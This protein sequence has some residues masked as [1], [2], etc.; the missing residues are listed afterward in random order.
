MKKIGLV[1]FFQGNFGSILQCYATKCAIEKEGFE[2]EILFQTDNISIKNVS[3]I[4]PKLNNAIRLAKN[5]ISDPTYFHRWMR[6]RKNRGGLTDETHHL[7]DNFVENYIR[8]QGY[9]WDELCELAKS[10]EYV[11]FVVGSDQVWNFNN[12]TSKIYGLEF[13]PREKR[14]ALSVSLGVE[15]ANNRFLEL[16]KHNLSLFDRISVREETAMK[17][18][19]K[20]GDFEIYRLSDPT[21]LLEKKDWESIIGTEQN[22]ED[23]YLLVHFLNYPSDLAIRTINKQQKL[24]QARVLCIGYYYDIFDC[25]GWEYVDCNPFDYVRYINNAVS[26]YTDSFHTTLFSI[27]FNKSFAVFERMYTHGYPQTSRINNLL[28]IYDK[29]KCFIRSE[30][31]EIQDV[32]DN[33]E[34]LSFERAKIKKYLIESISRRGKSYEGKNL[35][36]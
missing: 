34:I 36:S 15:K 29:S 8:P 1:T 21:I 19:S 25:M 2:C 32:N 23:E 16:L 33:R 6:Y 13:A 17:I 9:S 7:M 12:E 4:S 3:W 30:N 22:S 20:I 14:I 35:F 28:N 27:N 10:D 31:V 11:A 26:I 24:K 5:C 18:I